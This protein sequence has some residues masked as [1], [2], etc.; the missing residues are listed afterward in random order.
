MKQNFTKNDLVKYI[1]NET[2][3]TETKAIT[4]AVTKDVELNEEYELLMKSYHQLPKAKFEPSVAT[5]QSILSY[6]QNSAVETHI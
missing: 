3:N 2:S 4:K 5:I 1:Y 6:S